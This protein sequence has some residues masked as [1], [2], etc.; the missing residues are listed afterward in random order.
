M[1]T[2]H[3]QLPITAKPPR[4]PIR[5][6][7]DKRK[8]QEDRKTGYNGLRKHASHSNL[9][10]TPKSENIFSCLRD[11]EDLKKSNSLSNLHKLA[12]E[13]NAKLSLSASNLLAVSDPNLSIKKAA[14]QKSYDK[15]HTAYAKE[16]AS[17]TAWTQKYFHQLTIGCGKE[18]CQNCF[19]KS[20]KKCISKSHAFAAIC[21][22]ELASYREKHLCKGID[23]KSQPAEV[24]PQTV[25]EQQ[26]ESDVNEQSFLYK[27]YQ[28]SPF[29][30][31]FLPC[32]LVSSK[33]GVPSRARSFQDIAKESTSNEHYFNNVTSSLNSFA[34]KLSSSLS[35]LLGTSN[36]VE[37]KKEP[38]QDTKTEEDLDNA[39]TDKKEDSSLNEMENIT[40]RSRLPSVRLFGPEFAVD[41]IAD[42]QQEIDE[43]ESMVA[44]EFDD[45]RYD[46][47]VE[48][49]CIDKSCSDCNE[50]L[51]ESVL[52]GGGLSLT[53]LTKDMYNTV[54]K[55]HLECGDSSFLLN[56]IRTVFSSWKAMSLSF[57]YE[58]V[59]TSE[60]SANK[61][62]LNIRDV[63]EVFI[64]ILENQKTLHLM[65]LLIDAVSTL[66]T[67]AQSRAQEIKADD[68]KPIL[69]IFQLL[70]L[71]ENASILQD[72]A[73]LICALD[74]DSQQELTLYFAG[75]GRSGLLK[76]IQAFKDLLLDGCSWKP[77]CLNSAKLF[78]ICK[79]LQLI[80]NANSYHSLNAIV[81]AT[82]FYC[83]ELS[84][85]VNV[86]Q[87][88]TMWRTQ[89]KSKATGE[90]SIFNYSFLLQPS[91][92]VQVIRVEAVHEMREEYQDAIVHQ[93]RIQQVHQEL[94]E[95]D[96]SLAL[97]KEIQSAIC[98]YLVLEIRR[99]HLIEDTLKHLRSKRADLKKPLK[100][101]YVA[102]GEQ[103]LDLGGLQKEFF[104]IIIETVFDPD[105]GMFVPLE[106]ANIY[107]FNASSLE[108]EVMFELI[109]ILLGLAIYNGIIL[110][111]HL[112]IVV[113]K[114]LL[115]FKLVL[116]DL[117]DIEPTLYGSLKEI[118][119]YSGDISD[120]DLTFEIVERKFDMNVKV[121]LK[122][123]G[124][125]IPVTNDNKNEFVSLYANYILEESVKK[126]FNAF[127]KGFFKVCS[128]EAL[129]LFTPPELELLICGYKELDFKAL[130]ASTEYREG[131]TATHPLI[132]ELWE[133]VHNFSAEQ[134]Q[135]FLMFVTGSSRV[136]LTG[137]GSLKIYIQRNGPNSNNLPTAMTCF[138]RLLL[139]EYDT[140]AKLKNR[141]L[142]AI[143]NSKGFGLV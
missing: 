88:Y 74:K 47:D 40:T 80:Y 32:P 113:Y 53:H 114:K 70:V 131:F 20:S 73:D 8:I 37:N 67:D 97:P 30:S 118:L 77:P 104:Q 81:P 62:N 6:S 140:G 91:L 107:W 143:Q 92:K 126:V 5:G 46:D 19:C 100:I 22:I 112:P 14:P 31:L 38:V 58:G 7:K 103:G 68:I 27:L 52:N 85:K 3:E 25:F 61:F 87:E 121:E 101:K 69:I 12:V 95:Y 137:L 122:Y 139:P 11:T 138:N 84:K 18:N 42:D 71:V 110:D 54:V 128:G 108:S 125:V 39:V 13:R 83:A 41:Q 117:K 4:N 120:L 136:P 16:K 1:P 24:F 64:D 78:N 98:P 102:G 10:G 43:F 44:A 9:F 115:G 129:R 89:Q 55:D 123:G 90:D 86:K 106:E 63:E 109:G 35:C 59:R 130:E 76:I 127:K 93:V 50:Q 105:N 82:S 141:L 75:N 124:S 65:P 99:S 51:D 36:E 66:L 111:V 119:N 34:T 26:K 135:A 17:F 132:L 2:Q 28:A 60:S 96:D 49:D 56:S 57:P 142:L 23:S 72:L 45:F 134:K 33:L 79:V 21:S 116:E 29:R 94:G 48:N 133:I 15:P